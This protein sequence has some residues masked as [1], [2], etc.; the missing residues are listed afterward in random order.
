M[1]VNTQRADPSTNLSSISTKPARIISVADVFDCLTSTRSYR[2]AWPVEDAIAELRACAGTQFDPRMV[3]ALVQAVAR[4][5]WQTPD[6]EEPPSS[7]VGADSPDGTVDST[8]PAG[9][10]VVTGTAVPT[11]AGD[12]EAVVAPAA[13]S[14]SE[15]AEQTLAAQPEPAP[16][17]VATGGRD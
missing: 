17:E 6:V 12:T 7:C 9:S 1:A 14:G 13:D 15:A 8:A 5:G 11:A 3:E 16:A 10:A 2:K 4:E